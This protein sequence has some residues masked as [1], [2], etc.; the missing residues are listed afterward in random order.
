MQIRCKSRRRRVQCW[1]DACENLRGNSEQ[2]NRLGNISKDSY[3]LMSKKECNYENF[4]LFAEEEINDHQTKM[5][6]K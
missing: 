2:S 1:E 3:S 5:K 6:V 4:Y